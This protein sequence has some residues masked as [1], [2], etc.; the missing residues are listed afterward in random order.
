M[1]IKSEKLSARLDV[2]DGQGAVE[3]E[4]DQC[5]ID[6]LIKDLESLKEPSDHIHYFSEAWGGYHLTIPSTKDEHIPVH[7]IKITKV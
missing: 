1:D 6:K 3:I 2:D 4:L 5:A 7:Y